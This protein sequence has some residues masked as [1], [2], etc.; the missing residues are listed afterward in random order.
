M[1]GALLAVLV[2]AAPGS[3]A[4]TLGGV[5]A[6]AETTPSSA[7]PGHRACAER[8]KVRPERSAEP[9]RLTFVNNSGMYRALLRID[10]SG[11]PKDVA[12]LNPGEQTTVDTFR[13]H[14]WMI[15]DGPGDCIE[16]IM[17][18]AEPGIV[19]LK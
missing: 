2:L 4:P 14:P 1:V 11:T 12:G 19:V 7:R 17:P 5:A 16:I 9:T 8:S 18:A 3:L 15:T 10:A 13:T 6:H